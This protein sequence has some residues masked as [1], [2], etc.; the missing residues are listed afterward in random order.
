M[1]I[2][3]L[4][5]AAST[6][7]AAAKLPP[8]AAVGAF[9]SANY[10]I[11]FPAPARTTYCPIPD[12][13]TGSDH[14]TVIFLEPPRFCQGV[15]YPSSSRGF[16]PNVPRFEVYY[17]L[18]LEEDEDR[19]AAIPKCKRVGALTLLGAAR[20]LCRSPDRNRI[21]LSSRATYSSYAPTEV[22]LT[23]VTTSRRLGEDLS[24]FRAFAATVRT[25]KQVVRDEKGKA[26]S[27]WGVGP[28]C[29]KGDWY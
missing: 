11:T 24:R 26:S 6:P 20:P 17:G 16:E 22:V 5:V 4:A 13:W 15:G 1:L 23:L 18:D 19:P 7:P 28:E 27:S 14:G 29:P 9:A 12:T 25:C 2:A 8:K 21:V 3:V 10:A